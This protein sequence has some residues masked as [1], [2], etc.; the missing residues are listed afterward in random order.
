MCTSQNICSIK[1]RREILFDEIHNMACLDIL[2]TNKSVG[3]RRI[4]KVPLELEC[5]KRTLFYTR[6]TEHKVFSAARCA[7]MG[8]C[9]QGA[10]SMTKPDDMIDEFANALLYPGYTG[11]EPS[12]GELIWMPSTT[13]IVFILSYCP[14]TQKQLC[15]RNR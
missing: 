15:V 6:D 14:R 2:Q 7:Q 3:I 5:A 12:C 9:L 4:E 11:C 8:S 13:S 1:F 10:C